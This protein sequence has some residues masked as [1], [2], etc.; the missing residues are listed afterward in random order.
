[1]KIELSKQSP[2]KGGDLMALA[3]LLSLLED[4]KGNHYP[5][6]L[7]QQITLDLWIEYLEGIANHLLAA[8]MG[9]IAEESVFDLPFEKD[10][11]ERIKK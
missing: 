7:G 2:D 9:R 10:F 4:Y 11:T 3:R 6:D 1:M 5:E 8:D